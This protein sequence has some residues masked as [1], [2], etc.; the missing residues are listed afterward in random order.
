M[1]LLETV[2][3]LLKGG[4]LILS[5]TFIYTKCSVI[6]ETRAEKTNIRV[7]FEKMSFWRFLHLHNIGFLHA[8]YYWDLKSLC[9][10]KSTSNT[11]MYKVLQKKTHS[12]LWDS[13]WCARSHLRPRHIFCCCGEIFNLSSSFS[14]LSIMV[15][16][17]DGI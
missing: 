5:V 11:T 12:K 3:L 2:Q 13:P 4:N 8:K 10:T 1:P 17:I 14:A 16:A 6:Y 7:N 15:K 9:G